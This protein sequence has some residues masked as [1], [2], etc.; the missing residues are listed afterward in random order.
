MLRVMWS[1]SVLLLTD[2]STQG[3]EQ[4]QRNQG[5]PNVSFLIEGDES[6]RYRSKPCIYIDSFSPY[7]H[8]MRKVHYHPYFTN[9]EVGVH[10]DESPC[11]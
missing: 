1:I 3:P 6:A 7:N 5:V 9:R 11:S 10:R 2:G 4:D 8:P